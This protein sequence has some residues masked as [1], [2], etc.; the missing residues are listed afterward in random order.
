MACRGAV[1]RL[2][3]EYQLQQLFNS[4]W[5]KEEKLA[6]KTGYNAMALR[7]FAHECAKHKAYRTCNGVCR[8]CGLNISAYSIPKE[9]A[10]IMQQMAE[11]DIGEDIKRRH[12]A[13]EYQ[14]AEAKAARS[15]AKVQLIIWAIII[16]VCISLIMYCRSS[17]AKSTNSMSTQTT[18]QSVSTVTTPVSKQTPVDPLVPIRSTL[19][20][21]TKRDMDGDGKVACV[22]Y[23]LMFYDTYPNKNNVRVIWNK[24][25]VNDMNHLFVK[26]W[27]N[28][29]WMP[30]EPQAYINPV[31]DRWFSM[32]KYWGSKYSPDY[33]LDVTAN[34]EKIRQR[35]F[36]WSR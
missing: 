26:V 6:A 28:G 11:L 25:T 9:D 5:K 14:Q 20:Q 21:V 15:A 4:C 33:D 8:S 12:Q 31:T 24:N 23:T 16:T 10:V 27:V 13:I 30:V 18:T 22:D 35:T 3:A 29:E 17:A 7:R 1:A 36:V 19:K 34:V 32:R 2:Q